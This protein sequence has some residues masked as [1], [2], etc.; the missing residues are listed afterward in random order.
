MGN[1][2]CALVR[3]DHDDIDRAFSAMIDPATPPKELSN[4]LE[5][6]RLAL[7]VHSA[8]EAKVIDLLLARAEGPRS[9]PSLASQTRLEHVAQRAAADALVRLRPGSIG[10]YEHAIELRVLV[11]E[12]AGRADHWRWTVLEHVSPVLRDVLRGEYA[13][14][15]MRVLA[16]T[17][18]LAI[19]SQR[20]HV[21]SVN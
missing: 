3:R 18:P 19:A 5:V 8:A 4:L 7:A 17:S 12:H 13:T 16:S 2:V 14:E 10:W 9:L 15:R 11:L 6:L 21:I 20:E 1:D